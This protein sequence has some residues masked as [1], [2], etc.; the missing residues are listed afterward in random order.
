M[1]NTAA[2]KHL[3]PKLA[4]LGKYPAF[5]LSYPQTLPAPLGWQPLRWVDLPKAAQ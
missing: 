2:K 5:A 4:A 3:L 1:F